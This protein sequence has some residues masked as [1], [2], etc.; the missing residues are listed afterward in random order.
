MAAAP[1]VSTLDTIL[2]VAAAVVGLLA[3]IST[4]NNMF[5][6]IW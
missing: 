5:Q 6:W 3:V 4:L 1:T 2:A